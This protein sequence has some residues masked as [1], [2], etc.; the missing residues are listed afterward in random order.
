MTTTLQKRPRRAARSKLRALLPETAKAV[1]WEGKKFVALPDRDVDGWLE[2]L[3][4]GIE[5]SLSLREGGPGL[6]HDEVKKRY[7][8]PY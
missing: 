5:A 3:V 8:L 6:S 1:V 7:G 2:D 4:D